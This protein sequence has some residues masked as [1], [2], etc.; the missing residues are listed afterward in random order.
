LLGYHDELG[1]NGGDQRRLS[2]LDD[3][4]TDV[5]SLRVGNV[6]DAYP[7]D[8]PALPARG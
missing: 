2:G 8:A 5:E 6:V 4:A 7:E 3:G 1:I